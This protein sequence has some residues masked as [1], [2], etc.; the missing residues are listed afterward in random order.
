[1]M[2]RRVTYDERVQM[3]KAYLHSRQPTSM[4]LSLKTG[5]AEGE[6]ATVELQALEAQ[7]PTMSY[8]LEGLAGKITL[9]SRLTPYRLRKRQCRHGE[10]G[11]PTGAIYFPSAGLYRTAV[12]SELLELL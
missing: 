8:S 7:G 9:T 2:A 11:D 5:G 10:E 12:D 1:M 6:M 4:R 3:T